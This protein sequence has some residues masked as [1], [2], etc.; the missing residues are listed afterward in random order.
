MTANGRIDLAWADGDHTFNIAKIG[1]ILELE[2]KCGCGVIEVFNRLHENR[3]RF[4]DV[5]ETIRLGLI[6]GGLTPAQALTLVKRYVDERPWA[7]S[8]PVAVTVLMAAIVGVPGDTAG[9]TEADRAETEAATVA[10]SDPRSTESVGPSDTA[11]GKSTNSPS[12]NSKPAS[13]AS[14]APTESRT[15]PTP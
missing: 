10:L 12:G 3:W 9:K 8:V 13:K 15:S 14:S 11:H 6:G 7:E 2:D 1:Q 5:R 4:N